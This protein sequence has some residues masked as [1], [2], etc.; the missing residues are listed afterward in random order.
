MQTGTHILFQDLLEGLQF[1]V[2]S[3][4]AKQS[5]AEHAPAERVLED[6]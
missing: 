3:I 2:I 6:A 5:A 4:P 1:E